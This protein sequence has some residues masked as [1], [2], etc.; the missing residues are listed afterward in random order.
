MR[1]PISFVRCAT[2]YD[3]TPY[4][5]AHVN[6]S[7][8]NA[9]VDT[10]TKLRRR[11]ATESSITPCM[12]RTVPIASCGSMEDT[13]DR[14]TDAFTATSLAERKASVTVRSKLEPRLEKT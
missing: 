3:I 11:G 8:T 12:V 1:T 2:V 13:A 5:P 9:N 7:A 4:S 14:M 10:S 6:A